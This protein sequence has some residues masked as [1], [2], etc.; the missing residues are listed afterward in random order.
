MVLYSGTGLPG[1]TV[2]SYFPIVTLGYYF[3]ELFETV[4][5]SILLKN[6]L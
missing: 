1:P 5:S 6:S 4:N 3:K 2:R